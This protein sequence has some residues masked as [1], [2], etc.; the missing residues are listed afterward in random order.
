M[1]IYFCCKSQRGVFACS[2]MTK[3]SEKSQVRQ[4]M[5]GFLYI[6]FSVLL[7]LRISCTKTPIFPNLRLFTILKDWAV[8]LDGGTGAINRAIY[9][10]T[11]RRRRNRPLHENCREGGSKATYSL[12]LKVL[13]RG[14]RRWTD[15]RKLGCV[16]A[17]CAQLCEECDYA[18]HFNITWGKGWLRSTPFIF[19][20]AR[21]Q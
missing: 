20:P 4:C 2:P 13:Q 5:F 10:S 12:T 15:G 17:S 9:H 18:A 6:W 11:E 8:G 19:A 7:G 3:G 14:T 21:P 16:L 1:A